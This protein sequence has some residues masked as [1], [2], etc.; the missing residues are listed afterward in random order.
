MGAGVARN[1]VSTTL[2]VGVALATGGRPTTSVG[3]WLAAAVLL[4]FIPAMTWLSVAQGLL[5]SSPQAARSR[6][7]RA[8]RH[9][10]RRT[11]RSCRTPLS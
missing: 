11:T 10:L 4:L 3:R 1:C 6:I 9:E 5:A 8:Q 2:V 7:G